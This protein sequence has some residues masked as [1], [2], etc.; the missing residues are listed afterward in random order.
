MVEPI[1]VPVLP[2]TR[3]AVTAYAHI[4]RHLRR[5]IAPLW[6]VVPRTGP[7]RPRGRPVVP[8]PEPDEAELERWL[9]P[10][11]DGLID[12]MDGLGGWLD[13]THVE[14]LVDG[15]AQS[16]WRLATRSS[17]RLVTGPERAPEHQRYAADLAFL[18]G[19]GLGIRVQ[20][21]EQPDDGQQAQLAQLIDRLCLPPSRLDLLLDVGPITDAV[22]SGKRALAGLDLFGS[23]VAWRRVVLTAGAFPRAMQDLDVQPTRAAELYERQLHRS[24]REARPEFPRTV[25]YGDY[26]VEHACRAN[27][28]A[29]RQPGPGWGLL[30]YSTPDGFLIARAP[31]RGP[32][33]VE[34]A[35]AMARWIV[36]SDGF[37][38]LGGTGVS[39]AERWLHA[40][41]YG[42]GPR[43][44]GSAEKWIQIGHIQHL[45]FVAHCLA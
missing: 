9:T 34:R 18:S 36:E 42:S 5:R 23:L 15:S 38:G 35:R 30:R 31:T 29:V 8:D 25:V 6:T 2:M 32:D 41:A 45:S 22:E 37:R 12:V 7:E 20:L 27:I 14:R 19:L 40:C 33:H 24:L 3:A 1:Y 11:I 44:A 21:D 26:S 4:D 28:P 43:N 17:L 16:L 13:A 39:E 10:R